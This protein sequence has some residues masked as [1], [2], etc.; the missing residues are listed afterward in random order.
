MKQVLRF[1]RKFLLPL[2]VYYRMRG[3]VER[4]LPKDAHTGQDGYLI[5]SLYFDTPRDADYFDKLD[6]VELRR[7]LRLRLYSPTDGFAFLEMKQK[8][9]AYQLKRSLRLSRADVQS[10]IRGEYAPLLAYPGSFAAECYALLNLHGYRPKT[11]VE[12]RREAYT[13]PENE[14]RLTFD[15]DIRATECCPDL[16]DPALNLCPVMDQALVVLE[17]KY[18]GFLAE[19]VR[20]LADECQRLQTSASK[21][22]MGRLAA[23]GAP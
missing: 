18:N 20:E 22:C 19:Y 23:Y 11:I 3:R 12:Y 13:A 21:Y 7:K 10:L 14:T 17:V 8:Q 5:R 6:G 4:L 2:E 1:E 15:R 9:G 16:F